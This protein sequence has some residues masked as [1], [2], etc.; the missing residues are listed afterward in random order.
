MIYISFD[1][2]IKNLALCILKQTAEEIHVIDWRI[3]ALADK[4][5]D[6]KGIDD[7]AE[8]IYMELDNIIGYLK[9]KGFNSIEYVLIENQPSNLNGIMKT[10]QYIIYCYFSLLKYWDK[11][12]DNVVLVNASLKTKTHEY[13]PDIQI[14]MDETKKTKN[15]KGFRSDKYKMNKQ[16]SIEICKHYIKEDESLCNIFDNNKKKD[17]LCDACLQAVAY[18]RTNN[19]DAVSK[20]LYNTLSFEDVQD[21]QDIQDVKDVKDVQPIM[22]S[23][24]SYTINNPNNLVIVDFCDDYNVIPF[25]HRCSSAL[26]CKYSNLRKHSLPFDWVIPLYPNKIKDILENNF[27]DFIP[28]VHRNIFHNKYNV[29]LKHFNPDITAGIEEYNRR[30]ERFNKVIIEPSTKYFIYINEDYLYE[31]AYRNDDLNDAIFNEMLDLEK[32]LRDKYK[33]IEY[34][35]IYFNFKC[36]KIPSGSNI[37]QVLLNTTMIFDNRKTAPFEDF[38][39]YCGKILAELFKTSLTLGR[40]KEDI[41]SN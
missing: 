14:K 20:G 2:G 30:I 34:R 1:I 23:L 29:S 26:A 33:G 27:E 5:K 10:I 37:V 11:M 39:D 7:I 18:I 21:V 4:K 3:I 12:I 31:D 16:T 9:G 35:I 6:I 22:N 32:Y 40:Y 24:F 19:P 17:D 41:F 25:G 36:H 38:R 8:R 28:D 15:S 13:K